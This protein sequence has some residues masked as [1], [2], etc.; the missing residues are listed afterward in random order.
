MTKKEYKK[1]IVYYTDSRLERNLDKSVR[2]QIIKASNGIP[3]I[4]VS[5]KPLDFGCNI[6]VGLKPR[7]YLSLYQQL[8]IGL[9]AVDDDSIIYLCEH[10]VFYHPSHFDFIPPRTNKI[11]FNLNRY[12][13]TINES[14]FVKSIGK[15]ALS[16]CVSYKSPLIS[17]VTEQ[18][19]VRIN[20]IASP[21][22]G[23]FMNFESKFPNIDIRHGGNFSASNRFNNND[24]MIWEIEGWGTP[25][26]FMAQVGYKKHEINAKSHLHL[27][28]ND[29]NNPNPV[30]IPVFTRGML[31]MLFE[32]FKYKIGAEVGVK[33]GVFS[34]QICKRMRNGV[35][36]KCVDSW[37]PGPDVEWDEAERRFVIAKHTLKKY[38]TEIIKKSSLQAADEDIPKWSLD[39]VYIDAAHDFNNVMQDIIVWSDRVRPGGIV[40]GHDYDN[41]EV[42]TA[43]DAYVKVHN[44]ELFITEKGEKYP[45]AHP[46]WFFAKGNK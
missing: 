34:E 28:F 18:V 1:Q 15:R 37:H 16:Q 35:H 14:Y 26:M 39:F 19:D 45:D 38:D 20:G 40:S 33:V 29:K 27:I 11:Y 17:H 43:V 24:K 7:S 4:S 46:S 25:R 41:E 32:S 3:I 13:S 5:Q 9:E 12:Y 2:R 22:I 36:L 42:R 6:C 23:P 44:H 21:C 30:T 8:L 31:P 10:D